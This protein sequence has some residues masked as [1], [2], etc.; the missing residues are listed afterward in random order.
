MIPHRG[1]GIVLVA[2]L[3]FV[4]AFHTPAQ[5]QSPTAE[6]AVRAH[7]A[8]LLKVLS[9]L[10]RAPPGLQIALQSRGDALI[11]ERHA[12]LKQLGLE[13]PDAALRLGF[14]EDVLAEL[15]D[16]LPGN[17][18]LLEQRGRWIGEVET[19]VVDDPGLL[20]GVQVTWLRV[21]DQRYRFIPSNRRWPPFK[22]RD[23]LSTEGMLVGDMMVGESGEVAAAAPATPSCST[24]GSQR[25]AVILANLPNYSLPAHVDAEFAKGVMLGNA[26]STSQSNPDRSV[27]DYFIQGSDGQLYIDP[28]EVTVHGPYTLPRDYTENQN[29]T[30]SELDSGCEWGDLI[31][32][33]MAAADGDVDFTQGPRVVI[34]AANN[35][36]STDN[37]PG[38]GFG[39]LGTIGCWSGLSTPGDG[40]FTA[41]WT[42]NRA[43][44]MYNR[45]YGVMLTAHE[46]GHNLGL[47]H[48]NF[49]NCG[50]NPLGAIGL[51]GCS[52]AGY[53]DEF[54]T[55]GAWNLGLYNADHSAD[56]LGWIVP[57][58]NY[59]VVD[60]GSSAFFS[61]S[62]TIQNFEGRPAGMKALKIRRGS[63]ANAWIWL[64]S[65]KNAGI[66]DS[67]LDNAVFDGALMH[68][69]E[70]SSIS[71]LLIDFNRSTNYVS[72]AA[73]PVGQS[74]NDPYGNLQ[75]SVDSAT[76]TSL[77]VT[78]TYGDAPCVVASPQVSLDPTT[79]GIRRNESGTY[80]VNVTNPSQNCPDATYNISRVLPDTDWTGTFADTSLTIASG[81]SAFTTLA[82]GVPAT[83]TLGSF[84]FSVTATDSGDNTKT[85]SANGTT[86]AL[87][88][89]PNGDYDTDN[90]NN[91]T[92]NCP[93]VANTDQSNVDNDSLGDACDTDSDGDGVDDGQDN[94]PLVANANQLNTDGDGAG[95]VCDTDDDGDGV[96]DHLDN[97]P[98]IAN[99]D[100]ANFDQDAEGDVCDDDD[101]NDSTPDASD[102][103]PFDPNETADNDGDQIG[104]N[105]DTDDDN[106]GLPDQFETDNGLNPLLA[107]DANEDKDSDGLTN[108]DE[109]QRGTDINS[110][111]TDNDGLADKYEVDNDLDPLDGVCPSYICSSGFGGWKAILL[112]P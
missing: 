95:D 17:A 67:D 51:S 38:C 44:Q 102:A 57:T 66:Y 2:A 94:C 19:L 68:Y 14:S 50:T 25:V 12:A 52:I 59:T 55:M 86:T 47:S 101:D 61:Q 62:Y 21:G 29:A 78:V 84:D 90:V 22:S 77:T 9:D 73:L 1:W 56:E 106:D 24:T 103:F 87:D 28:T 13:N 58:T 111:D 105:A 16:R 80:T 99:A 18:A 31:D 32:D 41:S 6:A 37:L 76:D 92:D 27:D 23:V 34:L 49:L 46:M 98:L 83:E 72:D 4:A 10:D 45:A 26:H 7:N 104:D 11:V 85:G 89:D 42:L 112:Q 5:A 110:V 71:T 82:V 81:G 70:G 88:L 108:L 79:L 64:E 3:F 40:T 65:R 60:P 74:W 54:S 97:C 8:G 96:D 35:S 109:Y 15:R 20:V 30:S 53:G 107:S 100:Q 75:I 43:D 33:A 63:G 69:V 93:F 39:G 36:N 48:S 91:G